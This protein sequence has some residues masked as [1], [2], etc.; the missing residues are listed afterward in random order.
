[1]TWRWSSVVT[2]VL[3]ATLWSGPV[4]AHSPFGVSLTILLEGVGLSDVQ[5]AQVYQ[6]VA[7]HRPQVQSLV[8]Q[9]RTARE[10]LAARL[11]GPQPVLVGDLTLLVQQVDQL[12][13][14]LARERLQVA[15]EIRNVLTPDQLAATA[16][17]R[18]WLAEVRAELRRLRGEP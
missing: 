13:G 14:Q 17:I 15:V 5:Q 1:M 16:E 7:N 10:A 18:Q 6:I 12:R 4:F 8:A 3:A 11:S 2:G 9:L